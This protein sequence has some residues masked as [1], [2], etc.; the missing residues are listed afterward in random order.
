MKTRR[1]FIRTAAIS[2]T[3][4]TA[5]AM[6]DTSSI[7]EAQTS[8]VEKPTQVA[9]RDLGFTGYKV[10]EIGMGC[11]NMREAELVH[12]AIDKGINYL[13]RIIHK[14]RQCIN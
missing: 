7:T 10:S 12:A 13:T 11:M 4:G 1:E 9:Y 5:C 3:V 6:F 14:K 2:G 8:S